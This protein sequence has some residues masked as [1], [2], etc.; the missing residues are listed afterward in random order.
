MPSNLTAAEVL[1]INH[2][3]QSSIA[4]IR[5]LNHCANETGDNQFKQLCQEFSADKQRV[6]QQMMAF[7]NA[8][9]YTVQ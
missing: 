7:I 9:A 4:G 3:M 6:S 8:S 5:F 2:H 1:M